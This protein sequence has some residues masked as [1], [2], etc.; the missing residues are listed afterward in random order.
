MKKILITGAVCALLTG[1]AGTDLA[2]IN[3]NISDTAFSVS[4]TLRGSDSAGSTPGVASNGM[5]ILSP[6]AQP[7]T[8]NADR[9]FH[10]PVD[11]DTA[12]ARLKRYYKFISTEE[13]ERIRTRDRNSEWSASAIAE[14]N[15]V[16]EASPGSYY[17]MGN[18]RGK[19][20]HLDIEIEKNGAGSRVY[21]TYKSPYPEHL[22]GSSF[23]NLITRIQQV[24]AGKVR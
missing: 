23:D 8:A 13:L 3:K 9:E 15:P 4:K 16:W 22:S 2:A 6:A 21:V 5:P 24:A 1:C 17:K 14:R 12:A 11:V 7:S 20:D 18:D 10:V 19:H